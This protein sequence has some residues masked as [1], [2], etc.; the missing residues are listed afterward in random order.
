MR[1]VFTQE[2]RS[3]VSSLPI[4][5]TAEALDGS[6]SIARFRI[7]LR[8]ARF[9]STRPLEWIV[10]LTETAQ[11]HLARAAEAEARLAGRR[12]GAADRF[13]GD[14]AGGG[15]RR[16]EAALSLRDAGSHR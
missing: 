4:A 6:S 2:S 7:Y 13:V 3:I 9:Q 1:T 8:R 16:V 10:A 12:V 15:S 11:R 14:A 5:S